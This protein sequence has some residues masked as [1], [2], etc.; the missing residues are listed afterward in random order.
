M[1]DPR[2]PA[3][4]QAISELG[5]V[6]A[7]SPHLDDA[8]FSC[9]ALLAACASPTVVTVF[10][11]APPADAPLTEW[12]AACGFASGREAMR[13]RQ[14]EDQDAMQALG[15][16]P[17]YLPFLDAQYQATPTLHAVEHALRQVVARERA[18]TVLFPLGLFHSDHALV[19]RAA[20]AVQ[21]TDGA[22]RWVAYEDALYRRKPGLLQRRLAELYSR[23][24]G[25]TPLWFTGAA[26]W[27]AK[28]Q[29]VSAYASQLHGVGLDR[30]AGGDPATPE[31]YWR[32]HPMP[33]A[34]S[35]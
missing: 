15:A 4:L 11:G 29:A 21:R 1:A 6:L 3:G 22:R 2:P 18:D 24:V 10:A 26:A 34:G 20:L 23:G 9:G 17:V 32:L 27:H 8:A 13:V 5:R 19:H 7:I 16:R 12:D 30:A 33:Q 31:G 28:A 14:A 35:P 25:L